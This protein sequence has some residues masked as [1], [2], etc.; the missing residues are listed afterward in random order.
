MQ[1]KHYKKYPRRSIIAAIS[2]FIMF[3]I[4]GFMVYGF[5]NLFLIVYG[6][7]TA[8]ICAILFYRDNEY[9]NN[10]GWEQE[11]K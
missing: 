11:N 5:I 2:S 7:V 4:F 6:L 1:M 10:R 8:V 3:L 9:W